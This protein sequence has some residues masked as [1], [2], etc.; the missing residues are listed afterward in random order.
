MDRVPSRGVHSKKVP[1]DSSCESLEG[2][3]V[4]DVLFAEDGVYLVLDF[5]DYADEYDLLH[6]SPDCVLL[7]SSYRFEESWIT[8]RQPEELH[9]IKQSVLSRC[10]HS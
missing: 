8:R 3:Y 6:R 7:F 5:R 2:I 9:F 4:G 10:K 1:T